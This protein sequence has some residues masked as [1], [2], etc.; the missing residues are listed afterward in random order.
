MGFRRTFD[1][2]TGRRARWKRRIEDGEVVLELVPSPRLKR[3]T[4]DRFEHA[5]NLIGLDADAILLGKANLDSVPEIGPVTARKL[6]DLLVKHP[7][8][9]KVEEWPPDRAV[10]FGGIIFGAFIGALAVR[11]L[12]LKP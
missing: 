1:R 9:Y 3:I 10:V 4:L 7:D 2:L 6:R 11:S 5:C 12:R 8:R